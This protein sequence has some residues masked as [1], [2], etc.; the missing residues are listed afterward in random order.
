VFLATM[1]SVT[2]PTAVPGLDRFDPAHY[3]GRRLQAP[4]GGARSEAEPSEA[5]Q[6]PRSEPRPGVRAGR[7]AVVRLAG[8]VAA[9]LPARELVSTF[10][11]GGHSC[12]AQR[13]SITA[14]RIAVRA[15]IERFELTPQFA[16]AAPRR[17]QIGG[18]ARAEAACPVAYRLRSP[19]R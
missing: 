15:L 11:H 19:R 5:E 2:N 13:F 4:R 8:E 12:P 1:L 10:G 14:I 18:V 16:S 17:R 7:A 3:T 6:W 9:A